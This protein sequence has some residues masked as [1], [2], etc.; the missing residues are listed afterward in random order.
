VR[1]AAAPVVL[2]LGDDTRPA[3][4][5]V[6]AAHVRLHAEDPRPAAA[7]LGLIRWRPDRPVT[8]FMHWLEHGGPQFN[9]DALS[10]GPVSPARSFYTPHVSVKKAALEAVGGFDERFPFAAL[11]DV[12]LGLRLERAG[13]VLVYHPEML[14]EH[15]HP[16]VASG[17][18]ARQERVGA[19]A[20][21][22]TDIHGDVGY[23]LGR[24]RWSW[25][26]HRLARPF[27]E[28]LAD[29]PLRPGMR[30]YVWTALAIS[31]FATG[32]RRASEVLAS[33]A[34]PRSAAPSAPR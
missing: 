26:A 4:P 29:R 23:L 28:E 25:P 21:L 7:V 34:G 27:L 20:R 5:G 33:G 17:F 16:Y 6:L 13:L 14:V 15:D 19:S 2:F 12:E 24:P 32:W 30:E 9:F 8:P 1:R 22:M 18:G 11:E 3:D 31:G 10:A